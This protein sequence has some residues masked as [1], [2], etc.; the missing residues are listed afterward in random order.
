MDSEG[1]T[2]LAVDTTVKSNKK[3]KNQHRPAP[4]D[5]DLQP[6]ISYYWHL[7]L[8]D[9][10][11]TD[12]CMDHFD[13]T[14]YGLRHFISQFLNIVEREDVEKR[15]RKKFKRKIIG[16]PLITQSDPGS[17]NYGIANCHTVTRQRLD[18]TLEGSLQHKW[19][20]GHG[21]NVKP[22]IAWS[23]LRH[24]W[25]P[26]FETV[27][28]FGLNNGLYK[29]TDPLEKLVFR[30][31][32]IPWLQLELDSWVKRFNSSKR[33]AD[34]GKILPNQIPDLIAAKPHM[35][36][37]HDY[38]VII[39]PPLFDEMQAK[40]APTTDQVFQLVPPNFGDKA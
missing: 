8:T 34:R 26:G 14:V 24:Q 6:L 18:P 21:S 31:L 15:K 33:R 25:T 12:H 9:Q 37:V 20:Q 5:E 30:W 2:T 17:E 13:K 22:E 32:A 4:P 27:L 35:F 28:D 38:K 39:P 40:W 3:K 11:V 1:M 16:I 10:Q 36:G 7:G 23:L 29:S 19:M